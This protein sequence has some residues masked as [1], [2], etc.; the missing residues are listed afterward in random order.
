SASN[1]ASQMAASGVSFSNIAPRPTN[2]LR[3][4]NPPTIQ[5]I[6]APVQQRPPAAAM[7]GQ[8]T[9]NGLPLPPAPSNLPHHPPVQADNADANLMPFYDVLETIMP[10]TSLQITNLTQRAQEQHCVFYL[11]LQQVNQVTMNRY[12]NDSTNRIEYPVQ[13]QLRC[14]KIQPGPQSDVFPTGVS[15]RVNKQP[16]TL[17]AVIPTNKPNAEPQRPGRPINLTPLCRLSPKTPNLL[18]M[19]YNYDSTASYCVQICLVRALTPVDLIDRIRDR[20]IRAADFTRTMIREKLSPSDCELAVTELVASLKCPLGK[21]RMSTP[22]RSE[23]CSHVQ[24]FDAYSYLA[25]N[26][27]KPVWKCPFC[28]QPSPY[29]QLYIDAYFQEVLSSP[30]SSELERLQFLPD[31]SWSAAVDRD[32]ADHPAADSGAA[33]KSTA[34]DP[35]AASASATAAAGSET[36]NGRAAAATVNHFDLTESDDELTDGDGAAVAAATPAAAANAAA[37]PSNAQQPQQPQPPPPAPAAPRPS[38]PI[39]ISL[40]SSDDDNN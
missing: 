7:L 11:T 37:S 39:V 9:A 30:T 5:P 31:G 36:Q 23:A 6:A 12:I 24:C 20:G 33:A 38:E 3:L 27:K 22:M 28:D 25:M 26:A 19:G 15:C 8:L 32:S 18:Q 34:S 35:S 29:G 2:S 16:V 21:M 4:V 40:D 13:V 14:L 17:P 10:P 1:S